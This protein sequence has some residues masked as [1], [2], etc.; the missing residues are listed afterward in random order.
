MREFA[1]KF[2]ASELTRLIEVGGHSQSSLARHL[3]CTQACVSRW[4]GGKSKPTYDA[5]MAMAEFF[6]VDVKTLYVKDGV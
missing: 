5:A 1:G 2:N 6:K 3:A 4:C